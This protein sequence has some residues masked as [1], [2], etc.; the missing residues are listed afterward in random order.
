MDWTSELTAYLA[1]FCGGQEMSLGV[2][3][4]SRLLVGLAVSPGLG[5]EDVC[6]L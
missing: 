1:D 4:E 6:H 2:R 5:W 3:S